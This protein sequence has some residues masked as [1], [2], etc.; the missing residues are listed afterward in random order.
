MCLVIRNKIVFIYKKP[1]DFLATIN[2]FNLD[3]YHPEV[4]KREIPHLILLHFA[5][6]VIADD[7]FVNLIGLQAS[8]PLCEIIFLIFSNEHVISCITFLI[9]SIK[10]AII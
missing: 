10:V 9:F 2:F 7:N 6:D 4:I 8:T 1:M 5:V 3:F